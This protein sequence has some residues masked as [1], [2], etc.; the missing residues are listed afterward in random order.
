MENTKT[1]NVISTPNIEGNVGSCSVS[2]DEIKSSDSIFTAEY[3]VV[4]VN[5][6]TGKIISDYNYVSY[7]GVWVTIIIGIIFG[8][9]FLS[10]ALS[11]NSYS[12]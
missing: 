2:S 3:H 7:A 4:Q 10:V 5:S 8:L 9:F 6:C 12:Y 1:V 11:S